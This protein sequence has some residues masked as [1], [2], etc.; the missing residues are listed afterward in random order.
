[1]GL[2]RDVFA[3]PHRMLLSDL[4][5]SP[6]LRLPREI[7]D[8]I[9]NDVFTNKAVHVH[10]FFGTTS[11]TQKKTNG[12]LYHHSCDWNVENATKGEAQDITHGSCCQYVPCKRHL[13]PSSVRHMD[14]LLTCRRLNLEATQMLYTNTMFYFESWDVINK[15]ISRTPSSSLLYVR[16]IRIEIQTGS[17]FHSSLWTQTLYE[18]STTMRSLSRLHLEI[19]TKTT[20]WQRGRSLPLSLENENGL[21]KGLMYLSNLPLRQVRVVIFR[22]IFGQDPMR[23]SFN[24]TSSVRRLPLVWKEQLARTIRRRLLNQGHDHIEANES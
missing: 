4:D 19:E 21:M 16:S 7:R 14:F 8:Q 12:Q 22:P 6:L 3:S 20:R 24:G 18:L 17:T 2:Q 15:F 10:D 5:P 23:L 11:D 1:M 9:Y 13:V